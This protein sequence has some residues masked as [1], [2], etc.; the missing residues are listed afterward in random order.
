MATGGFLI[1]LLL[2]ASAVCLTS[3]C[4]TLGYYAQAANGHL[5]LL[6]SARPVSEWTADAATPEPLRQRL[7]LSQRMRS[8]HQLLDSA[9]VADGTGKNIR[10]SRGVRG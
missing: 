9:T 3:G 6:Q 10:T 4:S 5:A 8:F 1:S 7:Q 2:A